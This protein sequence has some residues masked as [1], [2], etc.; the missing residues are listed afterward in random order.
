MIRWAV[1]AIVG[2]SVTPG[3]IVVLVGLV[4][5]ACRSTRGPSQAAGEAGAS[6]TDRRDRAA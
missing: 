5:A 6:T 2:W 3:L 1:E 4:L